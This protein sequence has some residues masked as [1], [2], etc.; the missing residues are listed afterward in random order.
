VF[1][2]KNV[3]DS[4]LNHRSDAF[5]WSMRYR[6]LPKKRQR[7]EIYRLVLQPRFSFL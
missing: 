1:A 3:L 5:Q 6:F 4:N 2:R 7:I